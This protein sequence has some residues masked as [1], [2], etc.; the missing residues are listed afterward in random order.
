MNTL[1]KS[2]SFKMPAEATPLGFRP[3]PKNVI[4]TVDR[5]RKRFALGD[6]PAVERASFELGQGEMLALLGPSGCGKTTTLRMIAGFE[7]P[8]A[9]HVRL[10][11]QDITHTAP[12]ARGIGF[13]FQD[14]ALFPHLTVLDNVKFGLRNLT[15]AKATA[16]AEEMLRMVGLAGLAARRPA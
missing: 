13:V 14:Y 3:A 7:V 10:R 16:R 9:G 5:L 1:P 2:L 4:L 11:G 6:A 15:R 8:D 12:E